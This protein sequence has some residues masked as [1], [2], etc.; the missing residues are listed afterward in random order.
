MPKLDARVSALE[1]GGRLC[2]GLVL[3]RLGESV[4]RA[5]ERAGRPRRAVLIPVKSDT[6]ML[7]ISAPRGGKAFR[8]ALH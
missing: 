2:G 8:P 4:E 1:R 7:S 5:I 6:P 3:L